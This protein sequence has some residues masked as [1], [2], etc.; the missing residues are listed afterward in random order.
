M[1][2][3]AQKLGVL[4]VAGVVAAGAAGGVGL[5][6]QAQPR[7]AGRD[8]RNLD[9]ASSLLNHLDTRESE[10]KVDAYRAWLIRA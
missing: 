10:L 5:W 9:A 6:T 8:R 7:A 3:I 2:G 4:C 1:A